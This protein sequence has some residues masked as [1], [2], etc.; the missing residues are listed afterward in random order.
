MWHY[1]LC[2]GC[3]QV[4]MASEPCSC[5]F[6]VNGVV[7]SQGVLHTP[8]R[9]KLEVLHPTFPPEGLALREWRS[10]AVTEW[11]EEALA[12]DVAHMAEVEEHAQ[13]EA[14][15]AAEWSVQR[16]VSQYGNDWLDEGDRGE[17]AYRRINRYV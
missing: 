9:L 8:E 2:T 3:G 10:C 5:V 4:V 12:A 1:V 6:E 17:M 7:D 11:T 15:H 16:F 14:E 13:L